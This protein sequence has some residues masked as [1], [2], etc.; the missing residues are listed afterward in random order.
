MVRTQPHA[1]ISMTEGG[2]CSGK[3]V[4]ARPA[5]CRLCLIT[6]RIGGMADIEHS[7][8]SVARRMSSS[9][10][11]ETTPKSDSAGHHCI[12]CPLICSHGQMVKSVAFQAADTSSILVGSTIWR[13]GR[14]GRVATLSRSNLWDHA[15]LVSPPVQSLASY[16]GNWQYIT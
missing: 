15:P 7:K 12:N 13:Y 9:L 2:T 11:S 10:I 3:Q 6:S 8:C 5:Q 14:T 1:T 16:R 4:W